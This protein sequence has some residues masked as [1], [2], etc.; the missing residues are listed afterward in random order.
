MNIDLKMSK[1]DEALYLETSM[2]FSSVLSVIN[3]ENTYF[4]ISSIYSCFFLNILTAFYSSFFFLNKI[5][6]FYRL[7]YVAYTTKSVKYKVDI[8]E[9]KQ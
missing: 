7:M 8:Y 5:K 9:F 4:L 2:P 3:M 6:A 1:K